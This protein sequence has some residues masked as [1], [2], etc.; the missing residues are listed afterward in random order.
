[1]LSGNAVFV[2]LCLIGLF[3]HPYIGLT[4]ENQEE[5]W[6][7]V[8]VDPYGEGARL[9]ISEGDIIVQLDGLF[10]ELHP[11]VRKWHELEGVS[12]LIV[13]TPG[14]ASRTVDIVQPSLSKP[15]SVRLL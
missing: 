14:E 12:V 10:P 2:T 1:L 3:R 9:G 7:V 5:V 11:S 13:Q 4:L 8:A 15:Y 6:T